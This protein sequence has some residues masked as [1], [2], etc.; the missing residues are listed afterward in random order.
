MKQSP[1][2]DDI[3]NTLERSDSRASTSQSHDEVMN[4]MYV[5][6]SRMCAMHELSNG[7]RPSSHVTLQDNVAWKT[8]REM[9]WAHG[10][11]MAVPDV[12]RGH[13]ELSSVDQVQCV[14][15]WGHLSLTLNSPS[16]DVLTGSAGSGDADECL[17][18]D[19]A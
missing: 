10:D 12:S 5:A 1:H 3:Q 6:F 13:H 14:R 15:V 2:G 11:A 7:N 19:G 18:S 17:G 4:T 8:M 16:I 9:Q